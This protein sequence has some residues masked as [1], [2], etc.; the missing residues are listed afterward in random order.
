MRAKL[1]AV[2]TLV[3]HIPGYQ[4][5]NDLVTDSDELAEEAGRLCYE[6]WN[7][8]NPKT[9]TNEGYLGNILD[10][11]HYSV[12][13]H[14]SATIY[15]DGVTRNFTHEHIRHR[16][17]GYSEVSQRYVDVG[18][19]AFAE[20][21]GLVGIDKDARD[22]LL[23]AIKAGRD[24][25]EAVMADLAGK[26][27]ERK[28]ARQAARH[29]LVSGTET[30]IL[31]SGNMRCWREMLWKRLSPTA[32]EEFRQMAQLVLAQLKAIAPNTFQDFETP[33]KMGDQDG[34]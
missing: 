32:D 30:K 25:Y 14:A 16:H 22:M 9:A 19:F 21:P 24:A 3:G 28:K 13:E 5:H 2:T 6:S 23:K 20:H 1:I 7:R 10:Q 26:G 8:P 17:F 15:M 29:A 31:V 12:M 27:T 4:P 18:S 33:A 34:R 11:G